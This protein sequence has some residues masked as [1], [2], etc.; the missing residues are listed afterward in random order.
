MG[1]TGRVFCVLG[2]RM[3]RALTFLACASYSFLSFF[4]WLLGSSSPSVVEKIGVN[5]RH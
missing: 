4:A 2:M 1:S 3:A 5:S